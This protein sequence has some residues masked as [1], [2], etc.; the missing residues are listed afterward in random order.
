MIIEIRRRVSQPSAADCHSI[1]YEFQ[2]D[3]DVY[4]KNK[5]QK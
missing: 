5:K 2:V 1:Q 3:F 4:P